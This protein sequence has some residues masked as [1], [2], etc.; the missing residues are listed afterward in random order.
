MLTWPDVAVTVDDPPS[1]AIALDEPPVTVIGLD[2][3]LRV[4]SS[5]LPDYEGP[6][7]A[8][9]AWAVQTFATASRVMSGDF[10][11]NPIQKQEV[12]NEAGGLTL[13]I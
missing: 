4:S 5:D 11:V 8:T 3:Y 10:S 12:P 2:E 6:Y 1:T 7:E 13:T 9:P